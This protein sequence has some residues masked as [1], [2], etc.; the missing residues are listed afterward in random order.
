M[1][2]AKSLTE[3]RP[4]YLLC[5]I[6]YLLGVSPFLISLN[7]QI[8]ICIF[9]PHD[10]CASAR[11]A[12]GFKMCISRSKS[13]PVRFSWQRV[14]LFSMR[15]TPNVI[16]MSSV[17]EVHADSPKTFQHEY[18]YSSYI[19]IFIFFL[20]IYIFIFFLHT[21]HR[22]HDMQC[23]KN[24]EAIK[25]SRH[26]QRHNAELPAVTN[27]VLLNNFILSNPAYPLRAT[28]SI[29]TRNQKQSDG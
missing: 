16:S 8:F 24:V 12:H 2:L 15:A 21:C 29:P 10:P 20:H 7:F 18:Q 25:Q 23:A 14:E 27:P 1:N 17:S 9:H 5:L 4:L 13:N 19:Y 6:R 22:I 11:P 28:L 26:H 3:P